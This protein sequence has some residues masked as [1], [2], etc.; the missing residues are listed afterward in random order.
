MLEAIRVLVASRDLHIEQRTKGITI[1]RR[2]KQKKSNRV[3]SFEFCEIRVFLG[4]TRH[5]VQSEPDRVLSFSNRS[6]LTSLVP[7]DNTNALPDTYARL[8]PMHCLLRLARHL[9]LSILKLF[10]VIF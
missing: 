4:K 1:S 3:S 2:P 6:E 7:T 10:K 9:L 8:L 5:P